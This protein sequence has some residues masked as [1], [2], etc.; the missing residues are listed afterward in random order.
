[1]CALKTLR[2]RLI[3]AA[4]QQHDSTHQGAQPP[5]DKQ[6]NFL[7]AL[8]AILDEDEEFIANPAQTSKVQDLINEFYSIRSDEELDHDN[9]VLQI[10]HSAY[11][12]RQRA[13][14]QSLTTTH[15]C[16]EVINAVLIAQQPQW[17]Q[18]AHERYK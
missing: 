7:A 2:S 10:L 4:S 5:K 17:V 9:R 11:E 18:E 13:N 12:T 15:A 6:P 14:K 16:S 3:D 1:V 8:F